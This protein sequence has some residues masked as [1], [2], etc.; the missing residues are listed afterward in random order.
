M[1]NP[2]QSPSYLSRP[3]A[4]AET[5]SRENMTNTFTAVSGQLHLRAM[6]VQY[7]NFNN[8]IM[9]VGATAKLGGSHGWYV[10]LDVNGNV[11]TVTADQTDASTTWGTA[12]AEQPLP[13]VVPYQSYFTSIKVCYFGVCIVAATM[14]N[15]GAGPAGAFTITPNDQPLVAPSGGTGLTTPPVIGSTI[16]LTP[17]NNN[18]FGYT[19]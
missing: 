19:T 2:I 5:M 3:G 14:P 12:T 6:P 1:Q 11:L 9:K 10:I 17:N 16:A 13:F 15:L 8:G 7:A 4:T 18:I